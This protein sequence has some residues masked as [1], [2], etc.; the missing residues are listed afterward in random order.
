MHR[1][2]RILHLIFHMHIL[3][4]SPS[5]SKIGGGELSS[6]HSGRTSKFWCKVYISQF[7]TLWETLYNF[8]QVSWW[9]LDCVWKWYR[10]HI[11]NLLYWIAVGVFLS[12]HTFFFNKMEQKLWWNFQIR[13]KLEKLSGTIIFKKIILCNSK[14]LEC[15]SHDFLIWIKWHYLYWQH[16]PHPFYFGVM[17]KLFTTN[18]SCWPFVYFLRRCLKFHPITKYFDIKWVYQTDKTIGLRDEF[19]F[20]TLYS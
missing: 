10:N 14:C 17:V 13:P 9:P 16:L 19:S 20:L 4:I 18:L 12:G 6:S 2:I 7:L 5:V 15:K 11:S 1:L 3:W 8:F